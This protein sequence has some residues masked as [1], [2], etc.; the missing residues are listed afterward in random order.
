MLLYKLWKKKNLCQQKLSKVVV[1][2]AIKT[3]GE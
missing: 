1:V 3:Y 2:H